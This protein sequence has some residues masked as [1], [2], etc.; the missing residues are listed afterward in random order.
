MTHDV[1]A[2]GLRFHV[3]DEGPADGHA[4]PVVFLHGFPDTGELWQ[5]Q[6]DALAAAGFRCVAPDLRGRGESERP[7][8]VEAYRLSTMVGDVTGIMDA[9]GIERA[10]VVSHD[11]GAALGWVVASLAPERVDHF[12]AIS[13]GFP[14]AGP[15]D[16][17]ALQKGWYRLMFLFPGVAEKLLPA[18]DWWLMRTFSG[19]GDVDAHVRELSDGEKLT[20]ALNWYRANINPARL[21]STSELPPVQAP[22]MGIFPTGDLFLT[23]SGMLASETRVAGP[24]RYERLEGVSHWAP[25]E[26]PDELNRLLLDFLPTR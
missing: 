24:W 10:H 21:L 8:D 4:T 20:A 5:R 18:N 17:E 25:T 1:Q 16:L 23:E 9:L 12:V 13:V 11:W 19:G 22:T 26:A 3:R 14:G 15:Q 2:N 7:P 6:V